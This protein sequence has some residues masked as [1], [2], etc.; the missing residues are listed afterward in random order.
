LIRLIYGCTFIDIS[1]PFDRANDAGN[2][3]DHGISL[4]RAKERIV[5]RFMIDDRFDYGETRYRAWGHIDGVAYY[6]AYTIRAGKVRP[7]SLR[8]AHAKEMKRYAPKD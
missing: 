6:L 4:A 8:R 1:E 3:A 5:V 7:I 2:I